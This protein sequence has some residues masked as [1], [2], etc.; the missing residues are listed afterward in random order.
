MVAN[1]HAP[2]KRATMYAST[3]TTTHNNTLTA[4][5]QPPGR[6]AHV[7][8]LLTPWDRATMHANTHTTTDT[9]T[10]TA[11]HATSL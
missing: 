5:L 11:T 4:S 7:A 10:H 2:R 9:A 6:S 3:Y 1:L 8:H